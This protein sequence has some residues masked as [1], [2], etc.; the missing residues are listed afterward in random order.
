MGDLI[1]L[2]VCFVCL[3]AVVAYGFGGLH[4]AAKDHPKP[5]LWFCQDK[6]DG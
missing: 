4:A 1:L 6:N 3:A 2:C 5:D